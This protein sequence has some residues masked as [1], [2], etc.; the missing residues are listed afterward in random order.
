MLIYIARRLLLLIPVL[1]GVTMITFGLTRVVPG[2][3]IDLMVSP[4]ATEEMRAQ[5]AEREGLNDP[6]W[7]QYVH[8]INNVL[9]G[10]LSDSFVTSQPVLSDLT[11][12]FMP[13][14]ELTLFAMIIALVLSLPL[15]IAAAVW[16]NSW[17]DH[18]ARVLAVV[19]VGMPV[20]WLGLLGIYL[21]YFKLH[22]MPPPQGRISLYVFAPPTITGLYT[23]DSLLTGNWDAFKS[24]FSSLILPAAVLGFAAMAPLARMTRSG[25]IEALD[26]DYARAARALGLSEK[27]VIMRHAFRNAILPLMTMT[28]IVYGYMLGGVVL[29]ENV[30]AWPGLGRYV[31]TAITS[32][33]YPAIQGFILYSTALYVLI[34]LIVDVLYVALDPRVRL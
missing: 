15:G 9:H 17:V 14:F 24:A 31:F 20:F 25:M 11:S 2:N 19:G 28:A 33:D 27:S 8:Y 7:L 26:S 5:V 10:D 23:V 3:P 13:T 34:F 1:L 22:W 4:M 30:F 29:I 16:R 18:V 12:R 21:F 32:S 6:I